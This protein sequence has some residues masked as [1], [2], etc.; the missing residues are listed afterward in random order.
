MTF[1]D[2][3]QGPLLSILRIVAALLFIEH[4]TTKLLGFPSL[5]PTMTAPVPALSFMGLAGLI[6]AIGGLFLL[7]GFLTRPV[8][9]L[10]S[11]EMAIGYWMFH[12]PKS[13]FPSINMG[14]AAILFCFVF[15][16]LAA[17]GPGPWSL[18]HAH[19]RSRRTDID[20][21]ADRAGI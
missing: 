17:A 15:L 7:A 14:D 5:P 9:F 4:G 3:W 21:V 18:D 20:P 1:L 2:R 19:G 10:L 8:A 12:A 16:Y 13:T 6:E 11:G